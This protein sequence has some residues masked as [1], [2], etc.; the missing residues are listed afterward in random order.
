VRRP[1]PRALAVAVAAVA[2]ASGLASCGGSPAP[3]AAPP[4]AAGTTTSTASWVVV[5][6]GQL[7]V[8]DNTFY[9]LFVDRGGRWSLVTP[10]DVATNGGV[11]VAPGA[12][13]VAGILPSGDLGFSPLAA[14]RDDGATWST[15][16]LP[17]GLARSPDAVAVGAHG[18]VVAVLSPGGGSVV[19]GTTALGAFSTVARLASLAAESSR[20]CRWT[21]VVAVAA[22]ASGGVLLGGAC[23]ASG[24]SPVADLVGGRLRPLGLRVGPGGPQR[25]LRLAATSSGA[26][27]LVEGTA[28]STL[29]LATQAGRGW[30]VTPPLS[31]AGQLLLSSSIAGDGRAVVV[32][33]GPAGP[34]ARTA[35]AGSGW[36]PLAPLPARTVVVVPQAVGFDAI[37]VHGSR[38]MVYASS[39]G[40]TWRLIQTL[41][42]PIP[43]GSSS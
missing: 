6:M 1:G 39:A 42:I 33:R 2:A 28:G 15:G 34:T 4:L 3:S 19:Q 35:A 18:R 7:G 40:A 11:V 17:A 27:A 16:V 24:E 36:S 8:A 21:A 22:T 32:V 5:P 12:T 26:V 9:E 20:E 41:L 14:T 30:R 38:L 43:F 10:S 13:A 23:D 31:L 29:A 37:A 25:V